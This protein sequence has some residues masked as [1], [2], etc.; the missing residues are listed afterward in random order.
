M[1]SDMAL[2]ETPTMSEA[3]ASRLVSR[4][5]LVTLRVIAP[6]GSVLLLW[7]LAIW[8]SGLPA[9]VIP[10]PER[11]LDVLWVEH[12]FIFENLLAT[13]EVSAIGFIWANIAGI[14]LAVLFD[15][16]PPTR[17]MLLPAAITLRNVPY[18]ALISVLM[19]AFGDSILS[20]TAIVALS[21]FFPV[22]VNTLQGLR[23]ADE[24]QLDRMRILNASWWQTFSQVRLPYAIPS[25]ISAQEIT[26]SGSIIV[27]IAAEWMISSTG[28]GY[29]INHAMQNYRGDEVYAVALLATG[30]SFVIYTFVH[31]LGRRL[32]WRTGDSRRS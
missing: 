13:L 30:L 31:W 12:S 10:R 1:P 21:G 14:G 3:K 22:L 15:V 27:A 32:D 26:G 9:F 11:V 24:V 16:L 8:F 18:I 2:A 19:L 17:H 20:K 23:S 6:I 28:L 4:L 29:V 7:Y 25:I 5:G